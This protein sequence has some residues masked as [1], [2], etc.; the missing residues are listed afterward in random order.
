MHGDSIRA[1]RKKLEFGQATPVQP[2][3]EKS[4][5]PVPDSLTATIHGQDQ[6]AR[7]EMLLRN[8]SVKNVPGPPKLTTTDRGTGDAELFFQVDPNVVPARTS[9]KRD[10]T[11][12]VPGPRHLRAALLLKDKV[13]SDLKRMPTYAQRVRGLGYPDEMCPLPITE[14]EPKKSNEVDLPGPKVDETPARDETSETDLGLSA[15]DELDLALITSGYCDS[16]R[17]I[18]SL[19]V[20]NGATRASPE[21][22]G[23]A[24]AGSQRQVR[25]SYM[26]PEDPAVTKPTEPSIGTSPPK[27]SRFTENLHLELMEPPTEKPFARRPR[28]CSDLSRSHAIRRP[29]N[30][31]IEHRTNSLILDVTEPLELPYARYPSTSSDLS[32]NNAFR[33]SSNPYVENNTEALSVATMKVPPGTAGAEELDNFF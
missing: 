9:S 26:D 1:W 23:K 6:I 24:N 7:P 16:L 10:L 8:G 19:Y 29:A 30:T 4:G 12:N 32:R 21:T 22:D 20:M 25:F 5:N 27:K 17:Q 14:V 31:Y 33:G 2:P 15:P 3:F 13:S 11:L 28:T 18:D